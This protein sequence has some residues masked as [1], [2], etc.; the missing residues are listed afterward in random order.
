MKVLVL[1][2]LCFFVEFELAF[3]LSLFGAGFVIGFAAVCMDTW[4]SCGVA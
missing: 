1:F 2:Y 3:V 4:I